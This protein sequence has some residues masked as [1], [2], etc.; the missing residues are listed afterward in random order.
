MVSRMTDFAGTCIH[1]K[2]EVKCHKSNW[3]YGKKELDFF[4]LN[5]KLTF[6]ES[7][8]RS[9]IKLTRAADFKIRCSCENNL[10]FFFAMNA[11]MFWI[12]NPKEKWK[13]TG[14]YFIPSVLLFVASLFLSPF[15]LVT[16]KLICCLQYPPSQ[17]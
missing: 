2:R 3:Y 14:S 7:W 4:L 11:N 12:L 16:L 5:P 6:R 10:H 13:N 8:C 9:A 1:S 15:Q 17:I